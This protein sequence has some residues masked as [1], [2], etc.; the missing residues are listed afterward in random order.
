MRDEIPEV[1]GMTRLVVGTDDVDGRRTQVPETVNVVDPDFFQVIKLPLIAGNPAEVF[2]QPESIV[3]SEAAARRYF[4][5]ADSDRSNDH[6][7]QRAMR[8]Q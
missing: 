2:R 5:S 1:T 8:G 3:L 4:G 6:R 7:C